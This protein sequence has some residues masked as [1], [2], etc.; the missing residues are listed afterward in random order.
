MRI[1]P[2][3][4]L[5]ALPVL[6]TALSQPAAAQ[7]APQPLERQALEQE[8][9]REGDDVAAHLTLARQYR[10]EGSHALAIAVLER[11]QQRQPANEDVLEQLGYTLIESGDYPQ[12][13]AIFD[14]LTAINH[15]SEAG[16]NGKAVA[17]DKAGNHTAAQELYERALTINPNAAIVVNNL[18][19][20]YILDQKPDLAISLLEPWIEKNNAPAAM[21]HNLALAYGISG[22]TAKARALNLEVM[23]E[24]EAD[25]NQ[26]FY[27]RYAQMMK[28][29][30]R[31]VL[32][33]Q[34]TRRPDK[35]D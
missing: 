31:Q 14:M 10:A 8:V 32:A 12:A 1:C 27:E 3:A 34:A 21:R 9:L 22:K 29:E 11:A 23:S 19:L 17:F 25:A 6:L 26:A 30:Q 15:E 13:V 2:T 18:A 33:T 35:E 20:S 16:F 28:D 7:P 5:L 4:L 24:K